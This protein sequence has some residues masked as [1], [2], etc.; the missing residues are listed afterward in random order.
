MCKSLTAAESMAL[1][2]LDERIE[3]HPLK[4]EMGLF[5]DLEL[6]AAMKKADKL[7]VR[8]CQG[9]SLPEEELWIIRQIAPNASTVELICLYYQSQSRDFPVSIADGLNSLEFILPGLP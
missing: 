9:I 6:I 8:K 7:L 1:A 2:S 3:A 4:N 5:A